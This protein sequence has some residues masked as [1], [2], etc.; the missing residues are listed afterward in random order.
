[1]DSDQIKLKQE[2]KTIDQG[3]S[4]ISEINHFGKKKMN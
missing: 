4:N 1:M 2:K 3:I